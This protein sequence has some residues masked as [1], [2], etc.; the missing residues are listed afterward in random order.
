MNYGMNLLIHYQKVN[1]YIVEVWG[2][3][4]NFIPHFYIECNYSSMQRFKLAHVIK[5]AQMPVTRNFD[6]II[7]HMYLH[8]LI[9]KC[10]LIALY[11]Q[12]ATDRIT[13]F[14]LI[15]AWIWHGLHKTQPGN[16]HHHIQKIMPIAI[17]NFVLFVQSIVPCNAHLSTKIYIRR[18]NMQIRLCV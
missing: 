16:H 13:L 7:V 3:I 18:K 12:A 17:I 1:D 15:W 14:K 6:H 11:I 9:A 4:N 10:F 8:L 5:N 2:L